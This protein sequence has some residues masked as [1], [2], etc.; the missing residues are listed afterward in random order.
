MLTLRRR[1]QAL[2][3]TLDHGRRLAVSRERGQLA[4][5][6]AANRPALWH[7]IEKRASLMR[8]S[9]G[10]L[11]CCEDVRRVDVFG[12]DADGQQTAGYAPKKRKYIEQ[13]EQIGRAHV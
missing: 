7:A 1:A 6:R 10:K 5:A 2:R 4:V 12:P 13:F 9:P 3:L 11:S 8:H